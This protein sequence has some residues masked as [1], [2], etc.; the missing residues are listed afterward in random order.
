L[1]G[2]LSG[3]KAILRCPTYYYGEN[4]N[5]LVK[6][7]DGKCG[8]DCETYYFLTVVGPVVIIVEV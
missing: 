8:H 5:C 7:L 3:G 4:Y 1:G 2:I 6:K